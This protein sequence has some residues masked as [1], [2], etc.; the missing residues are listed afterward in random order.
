MDD[1]EFEDDEFTDELMNVWDVVT[2]L[3]GPFVAFVVSAGMSIQAFHDEARRRSRE[4][5]RKKV[6]TREF[7]AEI[8]RL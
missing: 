8:E 2:V 3:T 5:D 1:D 6:A 4:H 7:V